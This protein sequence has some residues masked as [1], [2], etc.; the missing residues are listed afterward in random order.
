MITFRCYSLFLI[1]Y[2]F[3]LQSAADRHQPMPEAREAAADMSELV[4]LGGGRKQQRGSGPATTF[5]DRSGCRGFEKK[6]GPK[7]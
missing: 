3:C 4:D 5:Q 6:T 2:L 1:I 7:E